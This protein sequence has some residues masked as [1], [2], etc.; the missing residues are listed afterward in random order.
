MRNFEKIKTN[1]TRRPYDQEAERNRKMKKKRVKP[2]KHGKRY[3][4]EF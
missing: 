3:G 1:K 2:G 4:E